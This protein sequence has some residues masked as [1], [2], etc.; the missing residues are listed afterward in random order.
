MS[1]A[2]AAGARQCA[3][4]SARCGT[5]DE[6][7]IDAVLDELIQAMKDQLTR[8]RNAERKASASWTKSFAANARTFLAMERALE[9]VLEVEKQRAA[10]RKMRDQENPDGARAKLEEKLDRLLLF[11]REQDRIK[12]DE[13]WR[14]TQ[15]DIETLGLLGT[16]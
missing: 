10:T 2:H 1:N 3:Q 14:K 13:E 6:P 4:K 8:Y 16:A 7:Q 12:R 9:R 5:A 11:T 15:E